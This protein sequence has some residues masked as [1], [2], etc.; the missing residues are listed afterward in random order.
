MYT[1][2]RV[3]ALPPGRL[4][5][6]ALAAIADLTARLLPF[7][8]QRARPPLVERI[9]GPGSDRGVERAVAGAAGSHLVRAEVA[10]ATLTVPARP[11]PFARGERHR[12]QAVLYAAVQSSFGIDAIR[13][14]LTCG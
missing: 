10:S 14:A 12:G 6:N 4:I 11:C 1:T 2:G 13:T 5:I 9:E 7:P 8:N 3:E